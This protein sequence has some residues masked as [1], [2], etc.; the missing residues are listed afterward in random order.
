MIP[1][2]SNAIFIEA[3]KLGVL[4]M[5]FL[6]VLNNGPRDS[7]RGR[8]AEFNRFARLVQDLGLLDKKAKVWGVSYGLNTLGE[9]GLF[10]HFE[11]P[12]REEVQIP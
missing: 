10:V 5:Q 7:K 3:H 11:M 6:G 2:N 8:R 4:E 12:V 1:Y 9:L